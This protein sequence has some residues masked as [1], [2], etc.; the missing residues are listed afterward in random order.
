MRIPPSME[1]WT[2]SAMEIDPASGIS[3]PAIERNKR[4]LAATRRPEKGKNPLFELE[5]NV[6]ERLQVFV[7]FGDAFD[8][9]N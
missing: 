1:V 4:R 9:Y 2:L 6:I 5:A 8:F 3:R 7:K